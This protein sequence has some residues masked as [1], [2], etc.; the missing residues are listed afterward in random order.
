MKNKHIW[1]ILLCWVCCIPNLALAKGFYMSQ[2]AKYQVKLGFPGGYQSTFDAR[3]NYLSD[4][5]GYIIT[6]VSD[7]CISG[8]IFG[9]GTQA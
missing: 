9:D 6:P 4:E 2:K 7:A 3:Y 5:T 8:E 1:T